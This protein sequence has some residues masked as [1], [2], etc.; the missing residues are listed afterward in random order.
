MQG[1]L[2]GVADFLA[3]ASSFVERQ[4]QQPRL[5]AETF[6]VCWETIAADVASGRCI[7][8]SA[9]TPPRLQVTTHQRPPLFSAEHELSRLGCEVHVVTTEDAASSRLSLRHAPT[10]DRRAQSKLVIRSIKDDQTAAPFDNLTELHNSN[11]I[12]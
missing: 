11:K 10:R 7:V 4:C 2:R 6:P 12:E 3:N 1:G 8:Y 5:L 9:R